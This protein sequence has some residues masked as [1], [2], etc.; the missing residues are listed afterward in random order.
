MIGKQLQKSGKLLSNCTKGRKSVVRARSV[1]LKSSYKDGHQ[2]VTTNNMATKLDNWSEL[3]V[4]DRVSNGLMA[5]DGQ[6]HKDRNHVQMLC[7]WRDDHSWPV[8]Q[9]SRLFL[10]KWLLVSSTSSGNL[11][12]SVDYRQLQILPSFRKQAMHW[13]YG[14]CCIS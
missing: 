8:K 14:V 4:S 12:A 3:T 2:L 6:I 7:C 11:W 10:S 9:I 5:A 1:S 13:W